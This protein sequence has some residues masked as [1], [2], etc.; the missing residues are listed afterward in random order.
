MA[1]VNVQEREPW[2]QLARDFIGLCRE[3]N[4]VE[5]YREFSGLVNQRYDK[6]MVMAICEYQ[7][8]LPLAKFMATGFEGPAA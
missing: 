1:I 2:R 4:T 3:R 6:S 7:L 8:S 5:K